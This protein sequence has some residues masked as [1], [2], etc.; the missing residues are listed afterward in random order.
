[1]SGQAVRVLARR[2]KRL[3]VALWRFAKLP[4]WL[5]VTFAACV[6]IPGPFDEMAVALVVGVLLAWQLRTRANRARFARY[7]RVAWSW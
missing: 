7:M 4:R 5:A 3:S 1:M 2:V 6:V